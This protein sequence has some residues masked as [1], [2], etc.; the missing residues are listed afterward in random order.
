MDSLK[1]PSTLREQRASAISCF[2]SVQLGTVPYMRDFGV[3][4]EIDGACPEAAQ[5]TF[6]L[7]A[8][9]VG[10]FIHGVKVTD[11]VVSSGL[12]GKVKI[13][14]KVEDVDG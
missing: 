6:A 2:L 4:V 1:R 14:L 12:D 8:E 3:D 10:R 9:G 7:A 13:S 5:R 11:G